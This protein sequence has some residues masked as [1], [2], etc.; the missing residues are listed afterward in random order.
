MAWRLIAIFL[1]ASC[2]SV[3]AQTIEHGRHFAE[4][5]GKTIILRPTTSSSNDICVL[6]SAED[7]ILAQLRGIGYSVSV[8]LAYERLPRPT[9]VSP[10]E[11]TIPPD[12]IARVRG[13]LIAPWCNS[14]E[15]LWV[16][17][18]RRSQ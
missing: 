2:A 1:L 7:N 3:N 16:H 12:S 13:Q 18:V 10:R 14:P 4:V 11:G 8:E 6:G 5:I 9:F 17:S 15:L